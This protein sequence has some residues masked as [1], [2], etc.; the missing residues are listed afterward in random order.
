MSDEERV[1]S[2]GT[3]GCFCDGT[4]ANHWACAWCGKEHWIDEMLGRPLAGWCNDEC[5]SAHKA[6]NPTAR[7][8]QGW[9]PIEDT[10]PGG[11][12][13]GIWENSGLVLK[14]EAT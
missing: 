8:F 13:D 14:G 11:P 7:H 1:C 6:A 10:L 12:Q 5:E 3:P 2:M 4:A 9:T